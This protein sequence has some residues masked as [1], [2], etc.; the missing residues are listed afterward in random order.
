MPNSSMDCLTHV[1]IKIVVRA[2]IS[3]ISNF[4]FNDSFLILGKQRILN[5]LVAAG[6]AGVCSRRCW[7]LAG[8]SICL[9]AIFPCINS[10]KAKVC[11]RSQITAALISC[12]RSRCDSKCEFS[13]NL[14]VTA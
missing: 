2:M 1:A 6:N 14:V 8:P 10:S 11:R 12:F 9:K 4:F 13:H 5:F 3:M 7:L